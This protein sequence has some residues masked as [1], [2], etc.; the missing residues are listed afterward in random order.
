MKLPLLNLPLSPT[1]LNTMLDR[2]LWNRLTPPS[3]ESNSA[4]LVNQHLS[5]HSRQENL[6]LALCKPSC[7]C[8]K[9]HPYT[10][11]SFLTFARASPAYKTFLITLNQSSIPKTVDE[12]LKTI[13]WRNAMSHLGR[14]REEARHKTDRMSMSFQHKI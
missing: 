9:P 10:I 8:V 6:L 1:F 4:E 2:K 7:T 5:E 12:A 11:S 13:H 14:S 3:T